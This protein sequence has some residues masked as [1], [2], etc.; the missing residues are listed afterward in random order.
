MSVKFMSQ[1]R[2]TIERLF[3]KLKVV[4]CILTHRNF[5]SF[6]SYYQSF[7]IES[8]KMTSRQTHRFR[9]MMTFMT[10]DEQALS[11]K[12]KK[13]LNRSIRSKVMCVYTLKNILTHFITSFFRN[14][15]KRNTMDFF[16]IISLIL[17]DLTFHPFYILFKY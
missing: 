12:Q 2:C 6:A 9:I 10:T 5:A 8:H 4:L 11:K 17:D 3:Q 16:S 7:K 14:L 13:Y 15:L 1:K